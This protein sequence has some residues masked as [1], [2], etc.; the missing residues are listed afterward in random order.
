MSTG[1]I[2]REF[3]FMLLLATACSMLLMVTRAGIGERAELNLRTVGAVLQI[4]GEDF[5]PVEDAMLA[6]FKKAFVQRSSGR[7]KIWRGLEKPEL[8][9]CEATGNGL[10][11]EITLVFVYNAKS[12]SI[13]GLRVT[14]QNETAGLGSQITDEDFF[15]QFTDIQ[16]GAGVAMSAVKIM[17]NQFDAVSGATMSSKAV[18]KIVNHAINLIREGASAI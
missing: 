14:E 2:S 16:A 10:W 9:A 5:L 6:R 13:A 17:N 18:E 11:A 7:V 3:R 12:S 4:I 8:W 15:E 1:Q